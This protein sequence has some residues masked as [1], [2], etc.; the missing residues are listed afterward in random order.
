MSNVPVLIIKDGLINIVDRVQNA[1]AFHLAVWEYMCKKHSL[2]QRHGSP[3]REETDELWRRTLQLPRED[4][5]VLVATY[6]YMWH[7]AA[8]LREMIPALTKCIV[9]N[10]AEVG[11][12]LL[13]H[14]KSDMIGAALD[15]SIVDM[16]YCRRAGTDDSVGYHQLDEAGH[17]CVGCRR[18]LY[19]SD[20][21]LA[22]MECCVGSVR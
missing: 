21:A 13:K 20:H 3:T 8:L 16:W 2:T 11:Y 7:P 10:S 15:M 6:D 17:E 1:R 19:R 9:G 22:A 12:A 4:Q 18:R 5:L 14:A